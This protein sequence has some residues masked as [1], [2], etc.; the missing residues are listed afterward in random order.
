MVIKLSLLAAVPEFPQ[1]DSYNCWGTCWAKLG[2]YS[3]LVKIRSFNLSQPTKSKF[4]RPPA[5]QH[6]DTVSVVPLKLEEEHM[7]TLRR[8]DLEVQSLTLQNKLEEKTW[9][10]EKSLLQQELRHFKQ[11]TF[12]VYVKLKW[13]LKHWRQGKQMEDDGEDILEVT[14]PPPLTN[15]TALDVLSLTVDFE[16]DVASPTVSKLRF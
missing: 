13:L 6:F 16:Y 3:Q 8:K 7:Q 9:S 12:L 11:D 2:T 15:E 10:Q 4:W 1:C 5:H 14:G